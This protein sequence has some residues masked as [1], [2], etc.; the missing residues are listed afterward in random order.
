MWSEPQGAAWSEPQNSTWPEPTPAGREHRAAWSEPQAGTWPEP[1][2]TAWSGRDW[3]GEDGWNRSDKP[4]WHS[5]PNW[6]SHQSWAEAQTWAD[7]PAPGSSAEPAPYNR[8]GTVA[9][10]LANKPAK[11]DTDEESRPSRSRGAHRVAAPP[12]ALKGR[13]AVVAVAAG[14]V[15]A[16]GQCA[17][18]APGE[19]QKAEQATDYEAAGSV[20]EI[21]AQSMATEG[22]A[23]A[24]PHSPQ[25]LTGEA[26]LDTSRFGEMLANG[27]E[28]AKDLAAAEEAKYRPLFAHF[29]A[30]GSFTSGYGARWGVQHL[31]VDIAAPIGTPIYAVADGEIIDAGP[32]AGFGMWVRVLHADGTITVYGHVDTTT[33]SIGEYVL[34][35]DQIATMGNRGFSTGP[36]VHFEVWLNGSDKVDP[37]PWL[38]TRGIS[39]TESND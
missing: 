8:P 7:D 15:V 22:P 30:A 38:A 3:H 18:A 5:D 32:A 11:S 10:A 17:T 35:G 25:M 23:A 39:L 26:P 29:S 6:N 9:E 34:A 24:D 37:I 27:A 16:A 19:Q 36:H 14:A 13:A 12:S 1:Q 2:T 21:A 33:V 31:G 28:F 20:H 4:A